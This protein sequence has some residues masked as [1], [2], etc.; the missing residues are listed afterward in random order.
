MNKDLG[1]RGKAAIKRILKEDELEGYMGRPNG[2]GGWIYAV[3][4]HPGYTYVR[5]VN[6]TQMSIAE[7]I[8]QGVA[9]NPNILVKIVREKGILVVR[10]A[11]AASAAHVL[12]TDVITSLPTTLGAI[13]HDYVGYDTVGASWYDF[14]TDGRTM[15]YRQITITQNCFLAA[16]GV[17]VKGSTTV[18]SAGGITIQAFLLSDDGGDVN[19]LLATA[20]PVNNHVM[21]TTGRW[22]DLVCFR[23]MTP[24]DYWLGVRGVSVGS[25]TLSIAYDTGGADQYFTAANANAVDHPPFGATTDSTYDFS[26]RAGI[27][28]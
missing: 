4:H 10:E 9:E 7:A 20:S 12:G 27:I 24:G 13:T 17:Y 19:Y 21:N 14:A 11:D 23:L 1:A 16:I 2:S 25:N 15:L 28:R 6:G 8:N 26:I 18:I 5:V 3:P 22:L